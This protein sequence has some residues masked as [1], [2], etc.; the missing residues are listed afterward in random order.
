M[1]T[2]VLDYAKVSPVTIIDTI[3]VQ[4]D[5]RVIARWVDFDSD[6]FG[7]RIVNI[8]NSLAESDVQ[9]ISEYLAPFLFD[10]EKDFL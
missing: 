3:N 5:G 6:T 10:Y 7:I 8:D 2:F 9:W 4:F 1:T